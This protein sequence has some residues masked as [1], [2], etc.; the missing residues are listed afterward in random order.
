VHRADFGFDFIA[1]LKAI[2]PT[3]FASTYIE[4]DEYNHMSA[5]RKRKLMILN[6]SSL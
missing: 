5:K 6:F 2:I 3:S 1:A 4:M